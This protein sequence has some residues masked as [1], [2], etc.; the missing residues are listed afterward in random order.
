MTTDPIP[1]LLDHNFVD[2]VDGLSVCAPTKTGT[3][4][5]TTGKMVGNLIVVV[6]GGNFGSSD[7]RRAGVAWPFGERSYEGDSRHPAV[8]DRQ[9]DRQ[10]AVPQPIGLSRPCARPYRWR[11]PP[12]VPGPIFAVAAVPLTRRCTVCLGHR[13]RHARSGTNEGRS[14]P[15]SPAG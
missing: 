3:D 5:R 2:V 10:V 1:M 13:P 14:A 8:R 11:L 15:R 4:N 6:S 12:V 7:P 9:D